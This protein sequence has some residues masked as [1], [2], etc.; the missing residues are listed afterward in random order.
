MSLPVEALAEDF[1]A[2]RGQP[3]LVRSPTGSGKSSL[4]PLWCLE[5]G[6]TL[7]VEPRRVAA[8]A[9]ARRC[10]ELMGEAVG[11]TVGYATKGDACHGASTRLLFATPGVALSMLGN[12]ALDGWEHLVLDEFHERRA[13]TDLLLAVARH[14]GELG[15]V[16]LLSATLDSHRLES[17]WGFRALVCEGR[18]HPVTIEHVCE[19]GQREPTA[20]GLAGRVERCVL[21]LEVEGT[22]LVFLPGV[23][24]ISE[25]AAW[26]A[27]RQPWEVLPLHG[28]LTPQAQDRVFAPRGER[29]R[30]VLSTNVAESAVTVPD[31]VAVID[32]GLER[33][34]ERD[35]PLPVLA[36]GAISQA[37]ADQR[38]GRAGRTRPGRAIRL[39]HAG[40]KLRPAG[41]PQILLEDP[42]GWLLQA[43][44]AGLEVRDLPW[45]DRPMASA[46]RQALERLRDAGLVVADEWREPGR[47]VLSALGHQVLAL[48]MDPMLGALCA[49]LTGTA[50]YRDALALA[51]ALSGR[52]LLLGRSDA[53]QIQARQDLSAGGG[54]VSLLA[55]AVQR[56]EGIR[57]AG[58]HMG[59]WREAREEFDRLCLRLGCGVDGWP[60]ATQSRT[61]ALE[62]AR[63]FPSN[64]RI[65]QKLSD[66]VW[67]APGGRNLKLSRGS[68]AFLEPTP[69]FL[70]PIAV[71][72][73]QRHDG[74][75]VHHAEAAVGFTRA[76]VLEEGL[77]R[78]EVVDAWQEGAVLKVKVRHSLSGKPLGESVRDAEDPMLWAQ[79][80]ARLVPDADLSLWRGKL[81]RLWLSHCARG[82]EWR[83]PPGEV[84]HFLAQSLLQPQELA[85]HH[86][87]HFPARL[88]TVPE[89]DELLLREA[90]PETLAGEGWV[91]RVE[92]DVWKGKIELLPLEGKPPVKLDRIERPAA[93]KGWGLSLRLR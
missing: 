36:L 46:L 2:L 32:S 39:W 49:R 83:A 63:L 66:P 78:L 61:L 51:A 81:G 73:S 16:V 19:S 71:H 93:W 11:H 56:T 43:L 12:G 82:G 17:E 9:L 3:V 90:F 72:G 18:E 65:R 59:A 77:G 13:E 37:S 79:A 88:P 80:V 21:R 41:A 27:S 86:L 50:A 68:L 45:L 22:V 75:V 26:L 53:A 52:T 60:A 5:A 87:P 23:G 30:V 54:D 6:P 76:Q 40:L 34:I 15:R 4:V 89:V 91:V 62:L 64:L 47:L 14:R 69:E 31:V 25:V 92:P 29:L 85:K 55:R 74:K 70:L 44:G 48:P 20:Q 33:R 8:R 7:V 10:A 1:R 28:G 58:L 57:E 35:G 24:E 38:A 84:R 42:Q 67:T